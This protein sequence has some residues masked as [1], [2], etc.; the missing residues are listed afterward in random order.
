MAYIIP[1][2]DSDNIISHL[3]PRV[4][5]LKDGSEATFRLLD[6]ENVDEVNFLRDILNKENLEFG[7]YP[8]EGSLSLEGFK[9]CYCSH[10]VVVLVQNTNILG[11]F[12]VKPNYPG[13]S[14]HLCNGG[15]LVYESVRGR[16]IGGLLAEMF[17]EVA[18]ALGYEGSVFNLVYVDNPASVRIWIKRNYE[19]IGRVPGA[20]K[21]SNG[22]F[23]DALMFYKK[24]HTKP[25]IN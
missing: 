17:E 23:V 20:K 21:L 10:T 1:N 14:S 11:S 2:N 3:F 24:F 4:I 25:I 22:E 13:R 16:G 5:T 19:Q 15:F 12:Y 7:T 8:Y 6:K 9:T 18:P